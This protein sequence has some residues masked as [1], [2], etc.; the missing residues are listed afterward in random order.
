MHIDLCTS[1]Y[2]S[3]LLCT[4]VLNETLFINTLRQICCFST[5]RLSAFISV[6]WSPS[7]PMNIVPFMSLP[8]CSVSLVLLH[9]QVS[10]NVKGSLSCNVYSASILI[11]QWSL[12]QCLVSPKTSGGGSSMWCSGD[13]TGEFRK[14]NYSTIFKRINSRQVDKDRMCLVHFTPAHSKFRLFP[15]L[16]HVHVY[17]FYLKKQSSIKSCSSAPFLS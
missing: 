2:V 6:V 17:G 11:Y 1:S 8:P 4:V 15:C 5:F 13:P 7:F 9:Q 16:C 14:N 12:L 3:W 10:E